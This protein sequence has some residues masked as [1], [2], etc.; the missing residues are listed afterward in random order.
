MRFCIIY[1]KLCWVLNSILYCYV[2]ENWKRITTLLQSM[3]DTLMV[4]KDI[5]VWKSTWRIGNEFCLVLLEKTK[6]L[7]SPVDWYYFGCMYIL[8]Y[9]AYILG[10]CYIVLWSYIGK[11]TNQWRRERQYRFFFKVIQHW[12]AIMQLSKWFCENLS[13]DFSYWTISHIFWY[14]E[15][16]CSLKLRPL[17]QVVG[18]CEWGSSTSGAR[19]LAWAVARWQLDDIAIDLHPITLSLVHVNC[20]LHPITW[21]YCYCLSKTHNAR[22]KHIQKALDICS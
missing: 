10:K 16:S 15:S 7:I 4:A 19:V 8:S 3:L 6:H 18:H 17:F 20:D 12:S 5:E 2:Q 13:C 22:E 1:F 21:W 9:I 14:Y 11:L